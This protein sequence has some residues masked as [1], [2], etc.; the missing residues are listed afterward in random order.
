MAEA[1]A[2]GASVVAFIQLTDRVI[3]V[4]KYYIEALHDCPRDIRTI[5]VEVSSLKAI[6]ENL[7]FIHNSAADSP[8]LRQ[9]CS[10]D[11]PVVQCRKSVAEL[12]RMLPPEKRAVGNKRQKIAA[13]AQL[14]AWPLKENAARRHLKDIA[15]Y[16]STIAIA[17]TSDT[18]YV[19]L[20]E[21][22][23]EM[24]FVTDHRNAIGGTSKILRHLCGL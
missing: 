23:S 14:L 5:L 13:A 17:L 9:V 18:V 21:Q 2:L 7:D 3:Q 11:G 22:G 24:P 8:L 20:G 1:I 6:L 19:C 12:E 16:K 10:E 15:G 4:S